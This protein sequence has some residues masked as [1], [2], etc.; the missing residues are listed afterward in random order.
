MQLVKLRVFN[1]R[2]LD[3]QEIPLSPGINLLC[4]S[5]GQGK[6]N[7]L[8][9]IY[10]L[11]YGKSFRTARPRECIRHGESECA[12]EG[13]IAHNSLERTLQ[14][15]VS[16]T[17]KK[18]TVSGKAAPV[19][20]FVG[21]FHVTAF[22]SEHLSIVRGSPGERRAFL[23]RA[24]VTLF[25][26]HLRLLASYGR[27]VKQRNKMLSRWNEIGARLDEALLDSWDEM[28]ARDG[29]RIVANRI[30]YVERLKQELLTGLFGAEVLKI[31]YV[32]TVP[33][34]DV[35]E[36]EEGFRMRLLAGR[37]ADCRSGITPIGPHRDDLK[38]Y[39]D[40]KSLADYGS[41]GQQRSCLLALYFTQMEIHRK[42]HGFYPVFL[43]DDVEAELDNHR[44]RT[45]VGYLSE[46]TQTF[47]TTAKEPLLPTLSG[48]VSRFIVTAGNVLALD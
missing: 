19:D 41:A 29:A 10:F 11:G 45:L 25:P 24:M 23:D 21:L 38:L 22:T 47:M 43:V 15:T 12:V 44:L 36:I 13:A 26:G 46:R 31:H 48:S 42:E 40:G 6:T 16:P 14:V 33:G 18:L 37:E 9:A 30:R 3:H 28:I 5:N 7:L 4:G 35:K 39:A 32:N 27:A 34:R 17:E 1:F 20:E 8:E 2:N